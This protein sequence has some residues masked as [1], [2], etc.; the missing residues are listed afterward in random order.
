MIRKYRQFIYAVVYRY[1]GNYDDT[2]DISQ[3]VFIKALDS[4]H[5]F[6]Q[7]SSL[8]SW[9]YRIAT[10]TAI[11]YQRKAKIKNLFVR[12]DSNVFDNLTDTDEIS[13]RE[14]LDHNVF[15]KDLQAA[16]LQLP[17]K[18]RETFALR[19]FENMPYKEISDMLNTSVGGLKANYFQ[20]VK[21]LAK[22][23]EKYNPNIEENDDE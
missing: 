13:S 16:L 20:A 5:R 7:N 23:L 2:Q 3:E 22:Y 6:K 12:D 10:N 15:D 11:T 1:V 21:K 4:L 8:K 19:F 14:Q 17:Q 18:Q 9:L